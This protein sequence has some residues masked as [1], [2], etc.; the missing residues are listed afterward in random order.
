MRHKLSK[1]PYLLIGASLLLLP[2]NTRLIFNFEQIQKIE[3]FRE[4]LSWSLFSFDLINL[5]LL[6]CFIFLLLSRTIR[7]SFKPKFFAALPAALMFF[8]LMLSI[9]MLFNNPD[10]ISLFQTARILTAIFTAAAIVCFLNKQPAAAK[11]FYLIFIIS[12][13]IQA[14][15]ALLQFTLQHSLGLPLLGE[16]VLQPDIWDVAK[17]SYLEHK[18]IRAYGTFPHPN[19]LGAFLL[20]AFACCWELFFSTNSKLSNQTRFLRFTALI[21]K[22]KKL[23]LFFT[24]GLILLGIFLTFS[25]TVWLATAVFILITLSASH[26]WSKNRRPALVSKI[27]HLSKKHP[28]RTLLLLII[29]AAAAIYLFPLSQPR[30]CIS[31]CPAADNSLALRKIYQKEAL[32]L[33]HRHPWLGVG[34]GHFVPALASDLPAVPAWN[35]QPAHNLYLLIA[36][37]GGLLSLLAFLFVLTLICLRACAQFA[38]RKISV[39]FL[40]LSLSF[41]L[42]GFFDHYFWTLAQG[43][44]IFWLM[45][46]FLLHSIR[47]NKAESRS[48]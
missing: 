31:R 1:I 33:I 20:A 40:A 30:L 27:F 36:A 21:E 35:R 28:L 42:L 14:S 9:S 38:T 8:L 46:A 25:R 48:Y 7:C 26:A 29:A 23:L 22:H 44:L 18:L 32:A 10:L 43:Q 6:L 15:I 12:G 19:L 5:L 37:E 39:P 24:G 47:M 3:G 34:P 45:L 4:H 2:F 17:F 13:T 16:S 41:L 11:Y